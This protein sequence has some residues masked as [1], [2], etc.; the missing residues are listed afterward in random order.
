MSLLKHMSMYGTIYALIL[1]WGS[2]RMK[3][4]ANAAWNENQFVEESQVDLMASLSWIV[5]S[6]GFNYLLTTHQI[7]CKGY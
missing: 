3:C 4:W 2:F 6:G 7:F 1:H 5:C